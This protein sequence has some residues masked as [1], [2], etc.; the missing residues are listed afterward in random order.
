MEP[1]VTV[2]RKLASIKKITEI[3][4]IP[5]ASLIECAIVGGGW[6]VVVQKDLFQI[7]NLAIYLEIDSWVPYDLAPFL[8]KNDITKATEYGGV[9][10]TRLKTVTM[11]GQISQGLLLPITND[12][13]NP[14][15]NEDLTEHLKIQKW[16][17]PIPEHLSGLVAGNFP[18]WLH[19][20]DQERCQ[21]LVNDLFTIYSMDRFEVTIKLD[22]SSMTVYFKDGK[23]GVCSRN[24]E[25]KED[26][27]NSYWRA[28]RSQ[29]V[30]EALTTLGLNI[31]IQGELIGE[32][33]SGNPEK[34]K[35]H[36]FYIFD[37]YNIDKLEYLRPPD[38]FLLVQKIKECGADVEHVPILDND[39]NLSVF[40]TIEDILK[41]A[42]GTSLNPKTKREGAVFKH[43]TKSFSFKA[44]SNSYLLKNKDS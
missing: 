15:E 29:K 7:G 4:P 35:G 36:R 31:A 43:L 25:L 23:V 1:S 12:I 11:R 2:I 16:E 22:G 41:Y 42:E 5:G 21:N 33:I 24:L 17:P 28:A 3:R 44:I 13:K 34:I 30:K 8:C 6:P 20:T 38:R 37:I 32:G 40:K 19:K 26:P 9:K 14:T 18:S 10:G 27:K 39:L